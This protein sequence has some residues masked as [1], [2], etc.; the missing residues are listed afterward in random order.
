MVELKLKND[1]WTFTAWKNP[2]IEVSHINYII[3]QKELTPQT[4]LTHYQGYVEF[5]KERSMGQV[6]SLFKDKTM[7]VEPARESREVNIQYCTKNE[8]YAGVRLEYSAGYDIQ[9]V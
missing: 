5:T 7:H 1:R 3:W 6:K 4:H 8:S 2:V 9:T